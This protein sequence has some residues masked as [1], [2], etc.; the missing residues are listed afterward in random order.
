MNGLD[1]H[2]RVHSFVLD[3]EYEIT[4]ESNPIMK[5][6]TTVL[7]LFEGSK[8]NEH[9]DTLPDME[10][11]YRICYEY[12]YSLAQ[13]H[14]VRLC[15]AS[16][17]WFDP[18]RNRFRYAWTFEDG[19]WVRISDIAPD[20]VWDKMSP[21]K[22]HQE[23]KK[24]LAGIFPMMNDPDFT[25]LANDKY[26]VSR[27]F[28]DHIKQSTRVENEEE[29]RE[30]VGEISGDMVV[31]KPTVG[32]GGR[33]VEILPEK[34]AME[35]PINGPTIVQEFIDGSEGIP[36]IVEGL[37]DLRLVFVND[38]LVYS[39]VRQPKEGSYLAN[40]AQGGTMFIV[41]PKELPEVLDNAVR[42]VQEAFREYPRKI[43]SIDLMFDENQRPWIIELNTMPG[44]YFSSDQSEEMTRFYEATIAVLKEAASI[45]T[46]QETVRK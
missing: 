5:Q 12:L 1:I 32:S 26:E 28:P 43:Y 31:V 10:E 7:I 24:S 2:R 6:E 25:Y 29:L 45:P 13:N 4:R 40:L 39:Y 19:K 9:A 41:D 23:F 35:I 38:A 14:G 20:L 16:H 37:H 33:G 36:G 22:K 15:R 46:D 44:I 18:E 3:W 27:M 8:A 30:V 21:K 11:K 17:R 34:E 42:D